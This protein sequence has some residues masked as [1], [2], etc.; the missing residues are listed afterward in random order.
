MSLLT[1]P[2]SSL[3]SGLNKREGCKQNGATLV[4]LVVSIVILSI[5]A[6]GIM[7]LM[8]VTVMGS[9][10]PLIQ[11]QAMAIARSYMDEILSKPLDDPAGADDESYRWQFDDVN[12]FDG[13][14]DMSGA[15]NFIQPADPAAS[16]CDHKGT[17]VAGLE[18]YNVEVTVETMPINGISGKKITVNVSHDSGMPAIPVTAY[19]FY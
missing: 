6:V 5:L 7:T 1:N 11:T 18:G 4:E 3:N 13:L 14:A 9:A 17:P 10:K 12:D 15:C 19:R 16:S 2:H 8:S